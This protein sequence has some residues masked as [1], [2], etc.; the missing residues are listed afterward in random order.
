MRYRVKQSA[1]T[2]PALPLE[3][4]PRLADTSD[5][6]HVRHYL[7]PG[8]VFASAEPAAVTTIVGSS[9]AL[10]MWD[11]TSGCGGAAHFQMSEAP[12]DDPGNTKYADAAGETLYR[13]LLDLG[14]TTPGLRAKIFGGLQPAVKF[15]NAPNC[16]GNRNVEAVQ[17]F[18]AAKGIRLAG[19]EV[20]GN[21]GRKVVFHTDDG[22]TWSE[23]L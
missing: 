1:P 4:R 5:A 17:K 10:C 12:Q 7:L 2:L 20:G 18:L 9:V 14:A 23:S 21:A 8:K 11:A 6:K 13:L 22:R 3:Y 19:E 15:G 16:L